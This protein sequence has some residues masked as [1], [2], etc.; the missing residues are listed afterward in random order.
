[1]EK[2]KDANKV[3]D[4]IS[5]RLNEYLERKRLAFPR[6]FFLSNDDLLSILSQTKEVRRV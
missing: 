1:L 2:F 4:D 6:F 3:L 5:K